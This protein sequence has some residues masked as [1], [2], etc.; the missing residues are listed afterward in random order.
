MA[1]GLDSTDT[2]N[3]SSLRGPHLLQAPSPLRR[4]PGSR[5]W[6]GFQ[7]I[8]G[9]EVRGRPGRNGR[10]A[11][12]RA[13]VFPVSSTGRPRR[14]GGPAPGRR[15]VRLT[16]GRDRIIAVTVCEATE[17]REGDR[18]HYQPAPP[19][20]L[21]SPMGWNL[22]FW[23]RTRIAPGVNLNWSRS[24]PSVSVGPRGA[25]VSVGRTGIRRTVGIPG[26][27]LFAT[28]QESWSSLRGTER[29]RPGC[30]PGPTVRPAPDS[31]AAVARSGATSSA[32]VLRWAGRDRLAVRDARPAG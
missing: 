11:R 3:G 21:G 22:R 18:A 17:P 12:T 30:H 27:W 1:S 23:R 25:K 32:A 5:F 26:T 28:D 20:D 31:H 8:A 7:A 29:P 9:R 13:S 24:A 10:P 19:P 2:R 6:W 14:C 16:S 4:G 15:A